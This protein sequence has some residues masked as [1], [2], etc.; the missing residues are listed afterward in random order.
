M[1]KT[2]YEKEI[3]RDKFRV[4]IF[5]SARMNKNDPVYKQIFS[6]TELLGDR[7]MDIVTGGGPGIMT[8]ANA[9]HRKGRKRESKPRWGV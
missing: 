9:G 5:G 4:T 2:E 1:K 3:K 7:G 6:L 8:A